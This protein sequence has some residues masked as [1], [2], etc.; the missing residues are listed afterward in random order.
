MQPSPFTSRG[1]PFSKDWLSYDADSL[2]DVFFKDG[3]LMILG[4]LRLYDHVRLVTGGEDAVRH[5]PY[6]YAGQE[7]LVYVYTS[8]D[9]AGSSR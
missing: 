7:V 4:G 5:E 8:D 6:Q 9:P 3:L 2:G 1:T